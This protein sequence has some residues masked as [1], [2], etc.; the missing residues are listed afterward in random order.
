MRK[1][2]KTLDSAQGW[3]RLLVDG[4]AELLKLFVKGCFSKCF[5][6]HMPSSLDNEGAHARTCGSHDVRMTNIEVS[7]SLP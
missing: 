3:L 2:T 1:E 6:I 7:K 4:D 5:P